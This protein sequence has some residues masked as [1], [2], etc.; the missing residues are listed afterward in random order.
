MRHAFQHDLDPDLA[1][2]AAEAAFRSYAERY[3]RFEPRV[4]WE[5]DLVARC[6]FHA[7][8]FHVVAHVELGPHEVRVDIDVPFLLRPFRS[9]ALQRVERELR[10]WCDKARRGE[11]DG[12]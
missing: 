10:A 3:A 4:V 2:R 6:S 11:L 1:R 7:K 5:S 9:L 12:E 8:G